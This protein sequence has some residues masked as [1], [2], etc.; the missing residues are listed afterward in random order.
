MVGAPHLRR[1]A[2]EVLEQSLRIALAR[3]TGRIGDE[4][5]LLALTARPG[6]AA[7]I[8]ADHGVTYESLTRVLYGGSGSG[9]RQRP[10]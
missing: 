8:L 4:H 9:R 10:G 1:D 5:L 3:L 7:E 2:K 6:T